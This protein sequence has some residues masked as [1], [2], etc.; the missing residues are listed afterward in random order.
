[1]HTIGDIATCKSE[2]LNCWLGKWGVYLYTYANGLDSSPVAETGVEGIIKSVGNSTT[3]PRDLLNDED[4][5]IVFQNLA[6][7]VAERM[8]ELGLQAR[9][10][11]IS[12]RQNDLTCYIRQRTLKQPTHI[13]TE[14]CGAAMELLKANHKWEMPLRSIGVRGANLVPIGDTRQLS[15]FEDE[16][17]RDRAEKLEFVIDDIRQ[18]FGHYAIDRA[19]LHL[20]TQLGKLKPKED[21]NIHPI[22]FL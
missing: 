6:E 19:L 14:I 20:D 4:A 8:R 17:R 15:F 3:C 18:K 1:L 9:T 16:Q 10:V 5:Q 11:E 12:L 7:S 13:S 2:Y 21:H 22:S